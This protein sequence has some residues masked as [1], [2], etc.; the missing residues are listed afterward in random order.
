VSDLL[1]HVLLAW[2]KAPLAKT[3]KAVRGGY[4]IQ[5]CAV[6]TNYSSIDASL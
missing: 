5:N 3:H 1:W 2:W 4:V 6:F